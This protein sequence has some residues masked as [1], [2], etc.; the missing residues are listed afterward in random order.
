MRVVH[1]VHL[2]P[3]HRTALARQH[4]DPRRMPVVPDVRHDVAALGARRVEGDRHV[5]DHHVVLGERE[6]VDHRRVRHRDPRTARDA[7]S[8]IHDQVPDVVPG[9]V[10]GDRVQLTGV[11][12]ELG[13][14]GERAL[15][16]APEVVGAHGVQL[17]V[18]FVRQRSALLKRQDPPPVRDHMGVA[19]EVVRRH[20]TGVGLAELLRDL[21]GAHPAVA[22]PLGAALAQPHAVH[23]AVAEHPVVGARVLQAQDVGAVAQIAAVQLARDATGDRQVEGRQLF[24]DRLERALQEREAA[25]RA[26]GRGGG[27]RTRSGADERARRRDR[28]RAAQYVPSGGIRHL[29]YS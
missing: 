16:G 28:R 24:G 4:T 11:R 27:Q 2:E 12:V 23:H 25:R 20:G 5:E 17:V 9:R 22:V 14:G 21:G 15:Q 10:V 19:R 3:A 8:R 13:V 18:E 6:V 29:P 7:A 26:G 1:R